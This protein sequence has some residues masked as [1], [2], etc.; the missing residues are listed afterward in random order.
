MSTTPGTSTPSPL[1]PSKPAVSAPK[2]SLSI[3]FDE[4][5]NVLA[6]QVV[7]VANDLVKGAAADVQNFAI[8]IATDMVEAMQEPDGATRS[9]LIDE[10]NGQLQGLAEKN[11]LKIN[12]ATWD[13]LTRAISAVTRTAAGVFANI[14]VGG[15]AAL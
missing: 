9:A 5:K 10:L 2:P 14:A 13:T 6:S 15:I 8:G 1:S 4:I 7:S 12:N 11:R 3:N